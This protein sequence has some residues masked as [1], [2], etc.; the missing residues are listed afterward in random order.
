MFSSPKSVL[1]RPVES[2]E[3][4]AQAREPL[5]RLLKSSVRSHFQLAIFFVNVCVCV[6]VCVC[7]HVYAPM[8]SGNSGKRGRKMVNSRLA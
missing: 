5:M 2:A 7:T 4:R 3:E 8:S 1:C 6:C